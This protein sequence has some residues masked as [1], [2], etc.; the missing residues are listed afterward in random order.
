M[1]TRIIQDFKTLFY[2]GATKTPMIN[3]CK[4]SIFSSISQYNFTASVIVLKI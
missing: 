2:F 4:S 1:F 3:H